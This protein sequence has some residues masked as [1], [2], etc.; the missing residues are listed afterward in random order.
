MSA[1]ILSSRGIVIFMKLDS[2]GESRNRSLSWTQRGQI[3]M[4]HLKSSLMKQAKEDGKD[5][6]EEEST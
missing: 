3:P 2:T 5:R 1:K 6:P 4:L